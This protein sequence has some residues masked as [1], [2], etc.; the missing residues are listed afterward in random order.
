MSS[1]IADLV[2]IIKIAVISTADQQ[3]IFAAQKYL[4]KI[5]IESIQKI[6]N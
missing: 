5:L 6:A 1:E 2:D 4:T 3:I